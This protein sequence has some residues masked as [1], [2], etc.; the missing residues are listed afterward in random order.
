MSE[1]NQNTSLTQAINDMRTMRESYDQL[2]AAAEAYNTG[3]VQLAENITAKGIPASASETLPELAEKVAQ[4]SQV[5]R[6][7][8]GGEMY[9]QQLVGGADSVTSPLWNLYEVLAQL[10]N[11]YLIISGGNYQGIL[12]CRFYK[13]Y[14]SIDLSLAD[15]YVTS[16]GAF[17]TAGTTHIWA[18]ENDAHTDRWVAYLFTSETSNFIIQ[19]Q[20][21]CPRD[22][23]IGGTIDS[24]T[25]YTNGRLGSIVCGIE[26][27]DRLGTL[28]IGNYTH[29]WGK[30]VV[31][32]NINNFTQS[33]KFGSNAE[34]IIQ[35]GKTLTMTSDVLMFLDRNTNVV[36]FCAPELE[37][38]LDNYAY[39]NCS[40]AFRYNT[41]LVSIRLP[42]LKSAKSRGGFPS[43]LLFG[44]GAH[45][46]LIDFEVG[47][48]EHNILLDAWKP[49]AVLASTNMTAQL[50]QNV[51]NH[52]LA[53]ISDR[54]GLP[55]LTCI[56]SED[57]YNAIASTN[58]EW[59]GETMSLADAFLT[60]NWL[61]A[62]A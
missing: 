4:I 54:T 30:D 38:V 31:L 58:I 8:D 40:Q 13:G 24:I 60:K 39:D 47:E 36:F 15:A 55:Q 5:I 26:E 45:T 3:K 27:T 61:L 21:L 42:K 48:M 41:G 50:V 14:E 37:T 35:G 16:D 51:K 59:Q 56:F 49:T 6:E 46:R 11:Q 22:I 20:S 9:Q 34:N 33:I 62:G 18:D 10:K 44:V 19:T 25:F 29:L 52:I 28:N 53:K 17:Y 7:I 2:G 43:S 23:Y 12:L 1:T 32:R 57:M